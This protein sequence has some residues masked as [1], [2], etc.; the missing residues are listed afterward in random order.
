[1]VE[2]QQG[3][4]TFLSF[5]AKSVKPEILEELLIG[6][7]DDIN[8]LTKCVGE[9]ADDGINHQIIVVGQRGMGKTHLLRV[10]YQRSQSFLKDKKLMIAYFSEE[11]YGISGYLDFL[12]RVLNAFIRWN[13]D[14]REELNKQMDILRETHPS[15]QID[16][17]ENIIT[18]YIGDKPL[19]ILAENFDDIMQALGKDGQGKLRS[20]LYRHSRTSI[21]ATSQALSPDLGREDRP[22]YNFFTTIYLKK[23]SYED[24]LALLRRLA[25]MEGKDKNNVVIKHL[26]S[27]GIAQ[28]RA[29][30][31]LV[32]GN[33]RLLVT[34]YEFLKA[35][36]LATLSKI[37]IK[38]LN[39]LKPY[40]ET[41]I[42]YLPPQQQK[43]LHYI[44]LAKIPQN[45]TEIG[46]NCFIEQKTLSK[47]LSEL[48]RRNL[49]DA[50][51]DPDDKRNKLYDIS[52]PLLR[53]SIEIGEHREGISALFID[54]LALYYSFDE[55][56]TQKNR[57]ENLWEYETNPQLKEDLWHDVKAREEAIDLKIRLETN[58]KW[59]KAFLKFK[60]KYEDKDYKIA[61]KLAEQVPENERS[62]EYYGRL[63][64]VLSILGKYEMAIEVHKK[65]LQF[66]P[67]SVVLWYNLA[68]L[69]GTLKRYKESIEASLKAI[70]IE[71]MQNSLIW[72]NLGVNYYEIGEE[73]K[74][75]E[76]YIK[77][78]EIEPTK[79]LAWENLG[80]I[81]AEKSN[82]AEAN[83]FFHKSIETGADFIKNESW[84]PKKEMLLCVSDRI[85]FI[86]QH[87][88]NLTIEEAKHLENIIEK[89]YEMPKELEIPYLYL[90]TFRRF[91]LE[92]EEKALLELPK[93][94]RAFFVREI[95][96]KRK[97]FAQN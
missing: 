39:D 23:L 35:D 92:K 90:K 91:V 84:M 55:L 62:E 58:R 3:I 94:Q 41:F 28:V 42:R 40:Y 38:T 68:N 88:Q 25:E 75:I 76:A 14:D 1:M 77:A 72:Y 32:K 95:L 6:R 78:T 65:A 20:F 86:L 64:Y 45:G 70:E 15:R 11:E 73:K 74:A 53:I 2:T 97:I 57:F 34:F 87:E 36:T 10:L 60:K 49:I 17:A 46:K 89:E 80:V 82:Y 22:F 54:F 19:L 9:I 5:G 67:K 43:I 33:H 29:M 8:Y 16:T 66:N 4:S 71:P 85:I 18:N 52:E 59:S 48:S 12:I 31:E 69:F 21:I 47:Q 37:F 26:Q 63:G 27:K 44:A 83:S 93:E 13:D 96:E 7:Q 50:I 51:T 61:I 56:A 79:W 30:H 24:S 81:Y